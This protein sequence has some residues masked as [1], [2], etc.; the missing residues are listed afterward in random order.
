[1]A[2]LTKKQLLNE[3]KS[4]ANIISLSRIPLALVAVFL[5]NNKLLLFLVFFLAL[6]TDVV[7][8]WFARKQGSTKYGPI[9]DPL[10]DKAFFA[11]IFIYLLVTGKLG[12]WLLLL[13]L[14]RDIFV[15]LMSIF[16]ML[17]PKREKMMKL[18]VA[19]LLGKIVTACQFVTV[20]WLA[21]GLPGFQ[22]GAY[23]AAITGIAASIEYL[24]RMRRT[25][26]RPAQ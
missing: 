15:V 7:D 12:W 26:T 23:A 22:T 9:I 14:L 1:M 19:S 2:I 6:L 10:A 20:L 5:F 8:G 16:A 24:L 4:T 21:T 13:L 25:I 17:H 11:I 18:G 3:L